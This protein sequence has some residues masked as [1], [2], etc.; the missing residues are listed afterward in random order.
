M[1][2]KQNRLE[3]AMTNNFQAAVFFYLPL[4]QVGQRKLPIFIS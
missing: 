4:K 3:I 2:T 1:G